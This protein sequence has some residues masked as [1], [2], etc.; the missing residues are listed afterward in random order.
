M[1]T[2]RLCA[3]N[4]GSGQPQRVWLVIDNGSVIDAVDEGYEGF[5][6]VTN[7]YPDAKEGP[8]VHLRQ[9]AYRAA[10]KDWSA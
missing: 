2:V 10:L 4:G 5:A 7:R 3:K 8:S 9:S 1:E 6:A